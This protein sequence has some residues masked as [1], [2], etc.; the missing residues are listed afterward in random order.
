MTIHSRDRCKAMNQAKIKRV[1]VRNSNFYELIL[2]ALQRT[3]A[4]KKNIF[5]FVSTWY[6]LISIKLIICI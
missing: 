2:H 5:D 1:A 3:F 4:Q 6:E